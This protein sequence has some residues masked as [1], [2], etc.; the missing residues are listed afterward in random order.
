MTN[1]NEYRWEPLQLNVKISNIAQRLW[2]EQHN[3]ELLCV[4]LH[5]S[6][7]MGVKR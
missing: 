6:E 1:D 2:E 5:K 7:L 4:K 3:K